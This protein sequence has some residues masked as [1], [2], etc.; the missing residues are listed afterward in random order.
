MRLAAQAVFHRY[1]ILSEVVV[2]VIVPLLP[3]STPARRHRK[4][5][6]LSDDASRFFNKDFFVGEK[7]QH[8]QV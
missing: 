7:S 2:T 1:A 4:R 6:E 5:L 8:Y 3:T